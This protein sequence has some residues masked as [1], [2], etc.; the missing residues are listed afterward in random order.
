MNRS[1]AP[2][3]TGA[4]GT[5]L[6]L[7]LS[8]SIF[9]RRPQSGKRRPRTLGWL[10][11]LLMM[12][13]AVNWLAHSVGSAEMLVRGAWEVWYV[14]LVVTG[15]SIGPGIVHR[16][17]VDHWLALPFPRWQLMLAKWVAIVWSGLKWLLGV[18]ALAA[19]VW[20]WDL[21]LHPGLGLDGRET[22]AWFLRGFALAVVVLPAA[23]SFTLLSLAFHSG[24][25]RWFWWVAP[26]L[27]WGV[28]GWLVFDEL[29]ATTGGRAP[30]IWPHDWILLVTLWVLA[31][32][33]L[34]VVWVRL[35]S[36]AG[37]D[38][39]HSGADGLFRRG[40][41]RGQDAAEKMSPDDVP[42][43]LSRTPGDLPRGL[44]WTERV[45]GRPVPAWLSLVLLLFQRD[46]WFGG[47]ARPWTSAAVVL[48]PVA[49][50][51][52]VCFLPSRQVVND[53]ATAIVLGS[54]LW[55][56]GFLGHTLRVL[57]EHA[58]W[59]LSL[60]FRRETVLW[61]FALAD[62][63]RVVCWWLLLELGLL[64]GLAV[65]AV[66]HELPGWVFRWSML[67][68]LRSGLL[69]I[70][71]VP[72]LWLV[73]LGTAFALRGSWRLIL[74]LEYAGILL[75]F[76]A[77]TWVLRAAVL[78]DV[79]TG[80]WPSGFGWVLLA[81]VVVGV[82]LAVWSVRAGAKQLHS[83]FVEGSPWAAEISNTGSS[84]NRG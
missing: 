6:A 72:L 45:T 31:L 14:G 23:S 55:T 76:P 46:R 49:V 83:V 27:Q 33:S 63:M 34:L 78:P 47:T 24:W 16:G 39:E 52:A 26:F 80:L 62:A 48:L 70:L 2:P 75:L 28:L 58:G 4:F 30:W 66:V 43:T 82:P 40:R 9:R 61:M 8:R 68:S 73:P 18:T 5:L 11:A 12:L 25:G 20:A 36:L 37:W 53:S 51:V 42:G 21:H 59:L 38:G 15:T 19:V 57:R 35:P 60:P 17:S 7:E 22:A 65:H 3:R 10:Y 64:A 74:L 54:V 32:A 77:G 81:L 69:V 67:A 29:G 84:R 41:P 71:A 79:D 1:A 13:L 50:A 56:W 44:R